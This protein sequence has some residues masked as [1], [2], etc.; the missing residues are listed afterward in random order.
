[1]QSLGQ[2]GRISRK[3]T[4]QKTG[5]S[6]IELMLGTL[7]AVII[8]IS[9]LRIANFQAVRKESLRRLAIEKAAGYL[10]IMAREDRP[11]SAS[12]CYEITWD[13][14]S[15]TYRVESKSAGHD[16][17]PLFDAG[18]PIGYVLRV[19]NRISDLPRHEGD[20]LTNKYWAVIDL[21]DRHGVSTNDVGR[22]FSTMSVYVE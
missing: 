19:S 22:P 14:A 17:Q 20:W 12:R 16:V 11:P 2:C 6:L 5:A 1:M 8:F 18:T 21:Y 15:L 3:V 10:D 7:V 4:A 9:W 13:P